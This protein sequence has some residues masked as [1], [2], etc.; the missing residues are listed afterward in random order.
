MD[1]IKELQDKETKYYIEICEWGKI[2]YIL[3]TEWFNTEEDAMKWFNQISFSDINYDI[4][5]MKTVFKDDDNY[6][7]FTVKQLQ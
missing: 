4:Y 3:Q 7:C 2:E 5:L 1:I 6:E